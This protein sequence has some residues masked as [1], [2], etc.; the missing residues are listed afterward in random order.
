MDAL[1]IPKERHFK[2]IRPKIF[3]PNK[4]PKVGLVKIGQRYGLLQ[5]QPQ[6]NDI[7]PNTIKNWL[8]FWL[9]PPGEMPLPWLGPLNACK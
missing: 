8:A 9:F 4:G 3:T 5:P 7:K 2:K 6:P 1:F